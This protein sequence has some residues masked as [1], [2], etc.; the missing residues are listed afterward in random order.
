MHTPLSAGCTA[1]FRF[2]SRF[3]SCSTVLMLQRAIYGRKK[4][5]LWTS[6]RCGWILK[7][8]VWVSSWI[9][10]QISSCYLMGF[11]PCVSAERHAALYLWVSFVGFSCEIRGKFLITLGVTYTWLESV[12]NL[13]NSNKGRVWTVKQCLNKYEWFDYLVTTFCWH[14][15]WILSLLSHGVQ[16]ELTGS[17]RTTLNQYVKSR[18]TLPFPSIQKVQPVET[19]G[20]QKPCLHLT[21]YAN[22]P[23]VQSTSD[24]NTG[25]TSVDQLPAFLPRVP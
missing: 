20:S 14:C 2:C 17:Q 16:W 13:E 6:V 8:E 1:S 4:R 7:Q 11:M 19:T 5:P 3:S 12:S 23:S 24:H 15:S 22:L 21:F 10:F 18:L 9:S 25:S